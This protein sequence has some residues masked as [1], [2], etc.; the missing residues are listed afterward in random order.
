[1]TSQS[2]FNFYFTNGIMCLQMNQLS[3]QLAILLISTTTLQYANSEYASL[4]AQS[5]EEWVPPH[6]HM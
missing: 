2:F 1:M 4:D 5:A 3:V 6:L